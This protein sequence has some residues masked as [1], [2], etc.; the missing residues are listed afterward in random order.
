MANALGKITG[1]KDDPE[2]DGS[3]I[4]VVES[5]SGD[6]FPI[7]IEPGQIGDLIATLQ[8]AAIDT[9]MRNTE[10]RRFPSPT[11]SRIGLAHAGPETGLMVSTVETGSWVFRLDDEALHN[12]RSEIDRALSLWPPSS[13]P[14]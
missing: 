14:Q 1:I 5:P 12:L 6:V 3:H 9:A 8:R 13:L 2:P 10:S 4:I 7:R 11:V